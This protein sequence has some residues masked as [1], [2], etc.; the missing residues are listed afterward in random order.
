MCVCTCNS[1][2]TRLKLTMEDMWM[3][4]RV[5]ACVLLVLNFLQFSEFLSYA[6]NIKRPS[7]DTVEGLLDYCKRVNEAA[8]FGAKAFWSTWARL[9]SALLFFPISKKMKF[10]RVHSWKTFECRDLSEHEKYFKLHA[11]LVHDDSVFLP[12]EF[13]LMNAS[14]FN[15]PV[16][17]AERLSLSAAVWRYAATAQPPSCAPP[18]SSSSSPCR[19]GEKTVS[20]INKMLQMQRSDNE[21]RTLFPLSCRTLASDKNDT[22]QRPKCFY[23]LDALFYLDFSIKW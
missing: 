8:F 3:H 2:S 13:F 5:Y 18:Y 20:E 19:P 15:W 1:P 11:R 6:V 22:T 9:N 17:S 21:T 14:F 4:G 16:P 12:T 7:M 10:K 23:E